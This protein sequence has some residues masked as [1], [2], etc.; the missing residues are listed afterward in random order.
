MSK[1]CGSTNIR[2]AKGIVSKP[3]YICKLAFNFLNKKD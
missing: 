1:I 3:V 2:Q